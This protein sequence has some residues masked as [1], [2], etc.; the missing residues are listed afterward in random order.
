MLGQTVFGGDGL[1][2]GEYIGHFYFHKAKNECKDGVHPWDKKYPDWKNKIVLCI[3]F[4]KAQRPLSDDEISEA[5]DLPKV[6]IT[7][8]LRNVLAPEVYEMMLPEDAVTE[9]TQP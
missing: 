8:K 9:T 7:D 1:V 6:S 2:V 4:K 5:Y 3:A